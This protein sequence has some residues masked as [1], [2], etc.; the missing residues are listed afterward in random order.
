MRTNWILRTVLCGIALGAVPLF[1]Q[2][3]TIATPT[4]QYTSSTTVIPITT[5]NLDTATTLSGGGQTLTFSPSL[6][7]LNV[8]SIWPVWGAPPNTEGTPT[9]VLA[10]NINVTAATITLSSP[11]ATFGFE[12][13][14]ASASGTHTMTATFFSG[15]TP[16]A[17]VTQNIP[18][19]GARLIAVSHTTPISS[20][21]ISAPTSG[22][23]ALAQFRFGNTLIGA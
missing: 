4:A 13:E 19:N 17:V 16:I 10:T 12:I 23:F 9:R 14:P 18:Y 22:G 1:A 5:A 20:V 11:Q 21:Q 15:A 6:L 2:P 8:P 7:A 3:F